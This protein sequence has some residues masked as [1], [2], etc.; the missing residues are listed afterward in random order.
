MSTTL[1][2]NNSQ[3]SKAIQLFVTYHALDV[4]VKTTEK[5]SFP[6][7][8][9]KDSFVETEIGNIHGPLTICSFLDSKV[10]GK[11]EFLS[12]SDDFET[13]LVTFLPLKNIDPTIRF[14]FHSNQRCFFIISLFERSN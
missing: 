8:K 5:V 7:S 2:L 13:S 14:H 9:R 4:V 1:H 10:S 6:T 3:A 12:R 11:S